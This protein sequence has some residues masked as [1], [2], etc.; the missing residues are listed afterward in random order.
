MIEVDSDGAATAVGSLAAGFFLGA[1]MVV[2]RVLST[3]KGGTIQS[4]HE[5]SLTPFFPLAGA[6][7]EP[8]FRDSLSTVVFCFLLVLLAAVSSVGA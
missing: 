6:L 7:L 1:G 4:T 5:S 3:L 2:Q 8:F